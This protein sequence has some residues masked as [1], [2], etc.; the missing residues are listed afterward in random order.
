MSS[1]ILIAFVLG[2]ILAGAVVYLTSGSGQQSHT[3]VAA[4]PAAPV[5]PA[6]APPQDAGDQVE[7]PVVAEPAAPEAQP[8]APA[9]APVTRTAPV[10][11][12]SRTAAPTAAER[13]PEPKSAEADRP[14]PR[15]LAT[16]PPP[17]ETPSNAQAADTIAPPPREPERVPHM[18]TIPAGTI[19]TVRI[20]Q[21]LSSEVNNQGDA[22]KASLDAP[23]VVDGFV[24]AERG[25]R[26]QGRIAEVDRGGRVRGTAAM[27][28]QLTS[29]VT[30]DGQKVSLETERFARQAPRERG[31]DAAK[32]GAAAGIGAAIGAIAG[33]GKGAALGAVL[34]GA[35]GAGGVMATRGTA[36]EIEPETRVSFRLAQ[37]VTVTEKL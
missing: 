1:R 15:V 5:E 17:V 29:I 8:P 2:A 34:G 11:P 25:A 14:L 10:R 9:P 35:A 22:F 6:Y 3:E 37:P 16:A 24:L 21:A 31:R 32:V 28:L 13:A 20:D 7:A 26:V 27:S 18:A 23:L 19:I 36:A 30:S 33:G 4:V 12:R